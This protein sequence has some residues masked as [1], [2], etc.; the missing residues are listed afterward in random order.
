M[1]NVTDITGPSGEAIYLA[2][3]VTLEEARHGFENGMF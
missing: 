1:E 3:D 2:P